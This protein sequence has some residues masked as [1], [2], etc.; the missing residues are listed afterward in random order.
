MSKNTLF[1]DLTHPE[2]EQD[3]KLFVEKRSEFFK[4]INK[5][6][7][8]IIPERMSEVLGS[9]KMKDQKEEKKK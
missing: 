9:P 8:S 3:L 4:K 2:A 6:R 1:Y 5:N 7:I